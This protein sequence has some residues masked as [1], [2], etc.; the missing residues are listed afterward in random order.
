[1]NTLI[2]IAGLVAL[3]ALEGLWWWA[4]GR[5]QQAVIRRLRW[6]LGTAA[7]ALEN[8]C[9]DRD[10]ACKQLGKV[11]AENAALRARNEMLTGLIGDR[12]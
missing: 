6:Q 10:E 11:E 3:T 4:H 2:L 1:M 8:A 7:L 9:A 12:P 5:H